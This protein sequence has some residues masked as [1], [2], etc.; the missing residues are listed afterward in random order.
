MAYDDLRPIDKVQFDVLETFRN[1][2]L[3]PDD[4]LNVLLSISLSIA[5]E[6]REPQLEK[7]IQMGR[8][9]KTSIQYLCDKLNDI[10]KLQRDCRES[11]DLVIDDGDPDE[12]FN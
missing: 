8:L 11:A 9:P 5:N 7:I 1:C 3:N 6:L 2:K 12:T 4:V 10:E